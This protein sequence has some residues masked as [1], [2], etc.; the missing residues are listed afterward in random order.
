MALVR[1]V[2]KLLISQHTELHVVKQDNSNRVLL[3]LNENPNSTLNRRTTI[4]LSRAQSVRMSMF[5]AG[6]GNLD[7]ADSNATDDD[8]IDSTDEVVTQN[9]KKLPKSPTDPE[10]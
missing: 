8:G 9:E 2:L 3:V 4:K 1:T 10:V 6:M 7:Q 5:M